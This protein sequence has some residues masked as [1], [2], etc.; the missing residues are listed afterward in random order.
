[1]KITQVLSKQE[2]AHITQKSDVLGWR[3]FLWNWVSIVAVFALVAVFPNP[4]FILAAIVLLGGRQ[5]ALSVL[6]H[7][8]GHRTLFKNPQLNDLLGQWACALPVMNDLKSYAK[9]HLKHHQFSGTE[10]DPD[11]PNYRDYPVSRNSF[12]RKVIR[13]LSGQTGFKLLMFIFRGAG[14]LVSREKRANAK[15]LYQGLLVQLVLWFLLFLSGHGWLYWLWVAAFLTS[16]M[17]FVRLRQVAEHA[18]V[19]NLFDLDPRLNTR[20]TLAH[21]WERWLLAPNY[22]N[23]H[24]EHHFMASVPC[25]R[26]PELHALLQQKG[27]LDG[28]PEYHGYGEVIR[29][30]VQH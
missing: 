9:G 3:V 21:W 11:L 13:D 19:P 25:Y 10:Q 2:M 6:M 16:Y 20:T 8:C 7:E 5:L 12:K 29:H 26:L 15:P 18:A 1:M 14:D 17:L 27:F 24:M 23:F 28:V 22:V 4:L 30:A